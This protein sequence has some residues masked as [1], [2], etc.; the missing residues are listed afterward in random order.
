MRVGSGRGPETVFIDL[1]LVADIRFGD[2]LDR[3]TVLS[4]LDAV[5]KLG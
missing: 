2:E 5:G 4:P 1:S 3:H